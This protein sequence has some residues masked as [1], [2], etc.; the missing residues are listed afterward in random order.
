M[1]S[2]LCCRYTFVNQLFDGDVEAS[3]AFVHN[4]IGA[5]FDKK[6]RC[7]VSQDP[8]EPPFY[9]LYDDEGASR[10][11][12]KTFPR[13][14]GNWITW[15]SDAAKAKSEE[16]NLRLEMDDITEDCCFFH[17]S[18]NLSEEGEGAC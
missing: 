5:T 7:W 10:S 2:L 17:E 1:C 9:V 15:E 14:L 11:V 3:L 18:M 13:I 8:E 4:S 6:K 12:V 16:D